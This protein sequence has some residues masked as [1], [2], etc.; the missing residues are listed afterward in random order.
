MQFRVENIRKATLNGRKVK[1]FDVRENTSKAWL[2]HGTY[3]A[4]ARTPNRDLLEYA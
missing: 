2:F 4:P 1:L 3:S